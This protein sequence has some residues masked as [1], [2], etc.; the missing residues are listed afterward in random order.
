MFQS[1]NRTFC[2]ICYQFSCKFDRTLCKMQWWRNS[3]DGSILC[4]YRSSINM[5][6]IAKTRYFD[7]LLS[8]I[9]CVIR[10]AK[11]MGASNTYLVIQ[12]C[13]GADHGTDYHALLPN[14]LRNML[15]PRRRDGQ[16]AWRCWD[17]PGDVR[18]RRRRPE[19]RRDASFRS[20]KE[21]EY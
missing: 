9:G 11:T 10:H 13:C 16:N 17:M 7:T 6:V 18:S 19:R 20:T 3:D 4:T 21:H 14:M 15:A 12:T 5:N 8:K 2:G 1:F